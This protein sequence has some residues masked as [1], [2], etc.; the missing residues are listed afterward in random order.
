MNAKWLSFKIDC[1]A[2][3]ILGLCAAISIFLVENINPSLM[4][5][6]IVLAMQLGGEAQ[7]GLRCWIDTETQMCAVERLAHYTKG[8]PVESDKG[9]RLPL[10]WLQR[11][12]LKFENIK[13]RYREGLPLVLKGLSFDIPSKS[14]VG[15]IG[16]TG[17]GKS[18]IMM[19]LY[20][21]VDPCEG[22]FSIDGYDCSKI[23][24]ES[25][26]KEISIIPQEPVMFSGTLR[27]NLDPFDEYTDD[28]IWKVLRDIQMEKH[29]RAIGDLNIVVAEHGENFSCGQRQLFCIGRALLRS[30]S[31]VLLDEATAYVDTA[32]DRTIQE[33]MNRMFENRTILVIAH[34]LDT[35]SD[36]DFILTLQDGRAKEFASPDELLKNPNSIYSQFTAEA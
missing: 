33:V 23:H 2:A 13:L 9:E 6:A 4:S 10:G 16:R 32:T 30:S 25:L 34:R 11:G 20:R 18:T 5:L 1:L 26:R 31:L 35:V 24:L 7:W 27:W 14:K 15:V 29:V 21:I 8:I 17:A 12:E 28:D 22:K 19:L 36:S 3:I